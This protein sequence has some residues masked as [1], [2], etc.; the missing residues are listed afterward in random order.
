MKAR[1]NVD[2][3][4]YELIDGEVV[5]LNFKNGNYFTLD[6]LAV[7][8]WQLILVSGESE[9]I[10]E[11]MYHLYSD[12]LSREKIHTA[13]EDFINEFVAEGLL[14]I[15][16]ETM[17]ETFVPQP[18]AGYQL[19]TNTLPDFSTLVMHSYRDFQ[20]KFAHPCGIKRSD[21]D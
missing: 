21:Q 6:G 18:M 13:T 7:F 8:F 2:N 1:L 9:V 11:E 10:E 14:V 16:E 4:I 12:T 5:I 17:E 15:C 20:E 19:D 3:L